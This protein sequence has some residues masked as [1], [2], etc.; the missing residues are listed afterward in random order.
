MSVNK[1]QPHALILPED[2]ANRQIA[3]GFQL[4]L[5]QSALKTVQVLP[6]ADGWREVLI[7]FESDHVAYMDRNVHRSIILLIDFDED[8]TRLDVVRNCIPQR[9]RDRVFVLGAWNEPEKLKSEGL[10][11]YEQIGSAVGEGCREDNQKVWD[12]RLLRHNEG[13]LRRLREHVRPILFPGG[14]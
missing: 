11:T 10:G 8:S 9:L 3:N 2:D 13:E 4:S 5:P 6:P 14:L 12:H 7:R 1:Y